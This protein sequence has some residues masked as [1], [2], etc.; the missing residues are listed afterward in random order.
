MTS[1]AASSEFSSRTNTP[2]PCW[3]MMSPSRRN[4]LRASRTT[5]FDTSYSSRI[6]DIDG[7]CAP[8]GCGRVGCQHPGTHAPQGAVQHACGPDLISTPRATGTGR[9]PPPSTVELLPSVRSLLHRR[10]RRRAGV[11]MAPL[12]EPDAATGPWMAPLS[13]DHGGAAITCAVDRGG[14][15]R[16]CEWSGRRES[17]PHRQFGRLKLCH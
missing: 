9:S 10:G 13:D 12:L 11:M 17:N 8:G 7:S 4:S 5:V 14:D 1:S 15:L 3:P 6:C 16:F 2:L